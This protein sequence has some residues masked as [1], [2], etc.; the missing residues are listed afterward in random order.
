MIEN[1]LKRK[2]MSVYLKKKKR[3]GISDCIGSIK[4]MKLMLPTMMI[5]LFDYF[6]SSFFRFDFLPVD[7]ILLFLF[8][9]PILYNYWIFNDLRNILIIDIHSLLLYLC[10]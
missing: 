7:P 2:S 1:F 5:N 4:E 9:V 6:R 3:M 10:G 8:N